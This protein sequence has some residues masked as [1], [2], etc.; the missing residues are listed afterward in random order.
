MNNCRA[1]AESKSC[2]GRRRFLRNSGAGDVALGAIACLVIGLVSCSTT[3][4]WPGLPFQ[5]DSAGADT[6][7]HRKATAAL[8]R[9]LAAPSSEDRIIWYGRRL[10]YLG[11]YKLAVEV[12]SRGLRIHPNSAKLL[13]HRGHRYISLRQFDLAVGDYERAVALIQDQPDEIEPDGMPNAL[14]I[15]LSTLHGN[16]W[17]HLGLAHYCKGDFAQALTC[18][19]ECLRTDRNQDSEV[20]SRYWIYHCAT[21]LGKPEIA[22]AALDP[23]RRNW[24]IIENHTYH[25]L[26]LLYRGDLAF[27]ELAKGGDP[28]VNPTLAYGLARYELTHGDETAG[29]ERLRAL[30]ATG[31]SS[32]GCIASEADLAR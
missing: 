18:Y 7:D 26:L 2:I 23:V 19:Q 31:S 15:P 10:G 9:L 27:G 29:R 13:R 1:N 4:T 14:N 30:A 5:L 11:E 25:D 22:R 6:G 16:I 20:A 21:Q 17:Y 28:T 8:D 24:R 12:Y 3:P 32:F